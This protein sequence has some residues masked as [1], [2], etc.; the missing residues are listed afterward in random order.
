[1]DFLLDFLDSFFGLGFTEVMRYD[2]S[3]VVTQKE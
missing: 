2:K 1:M 3:T